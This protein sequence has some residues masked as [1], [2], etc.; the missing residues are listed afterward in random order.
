MLAF[1]DP[2][3]PVLISLS[4]A[5]ILVTVLRV[6]EPGKTKHLTR[7]WYDE[8]GAFLNSRYRQRLFIELCASEDNHLVA[9]LQL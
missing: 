5:D 3:Q 9:S 7:Y 8:R 4:R 6:I 1:V 2:I